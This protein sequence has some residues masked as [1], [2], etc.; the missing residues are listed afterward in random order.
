MKITYEF[1]TNHPDFYDN[2]NQILYRINKIS[3][4]VLCLKAMKQA[5]TNLIKYDNRASILTSELEEKFWE[6]IE[7]YEIN[8]EKLGD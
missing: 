1:D 8:F 5:I 3:N 2:D 7:E 4:M 6:I